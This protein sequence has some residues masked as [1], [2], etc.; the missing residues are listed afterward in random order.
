MI[1]PRPREPSGRLRRRLARAE[2]ALVAQIAQQPHRRGERTTIGATPWQ[3]AIK[4]GAIHDQTGRLTPGELEAAGLRL[5]EARSDFLKAI[6]ASAPF[7]SGPSGSGS[8]IPVA[9]RNRWIDEW[10]DIAL[11]VLRRGRM[12]L[13]CVLAAVEAS[14][15]ADERLWPPEFTN[16]V[17]EALRVLAGHL[18]RRRP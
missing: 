12:A 7:A 18:S 10:A 3:R 5:A 14:P 6:G 4:S 9:L 16:A 17:S 8:D 11:V 1:S 2:D 13:R 15:G